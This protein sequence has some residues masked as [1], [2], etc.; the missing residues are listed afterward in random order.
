MVFHVTFHAI[1][2]EVVVYELE[3]QC[4]REYS[5]EEGDKT[6]EDNN[7][8]GHW[9]FRSCTPTFLANKKTIPSEEGLNRLFTRFPA[10]S[11]AGVR[12]DPIPFL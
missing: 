3:E 5:G 12:K 8:I 11:A 7:K 10:E 6:K 9:V 2:V 1:A 4:R